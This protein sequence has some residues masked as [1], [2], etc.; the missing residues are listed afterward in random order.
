V[1]IV[2]GH[3]SHHAQGVEVYRD[4]TILCGCGD[5]VNGYEGIRGYEEYRDDLALMY[6]VDVD[7]ASGALVRLEIVPLQIRNFRLVQ[8]SRQDVNWL[9]LTLDR[10]SRKFDT[11]V[12]LNADGR[13]DLSWRTEHRSRRTIQ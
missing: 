7:A 5:F 13:L 8:A 6:F 3:S 2:V 9:Q 10:E 4:R 11:R 12:A 1:S